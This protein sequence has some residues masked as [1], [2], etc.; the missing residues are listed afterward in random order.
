MKH[1][2][3]GESSHSHMSEKQIPFMKHPCVI[4]NTI[5]MKRRVMIPYDNRRSGGYTGAKAIGANTIKFG[6]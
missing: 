3:G 6:A 5:K 2:L 4:Q 1:R